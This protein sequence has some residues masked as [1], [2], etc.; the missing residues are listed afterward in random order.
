ML[1]LLV[2]H[3]SNE[4]GTNHEAEILSVFP[5]VS[6]YPLI[7]RSKSEGNCKIQQKSPVAFYGGEW[8][9][10]YTSSAAVPPESVLRLC[11]FMQLALRWHIKKGKLMVIAIN[12]L[13]APSC[14]PDAIY[15][16]CK[17][18]CNTRGCGCCKY[19]PECS[20]SCGGCK[21]LH[22]LKITLPEVGK[23]YRYSYYNYI[24]AIPFSHEVKM[25]V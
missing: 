7:R 1:Y 23:C 18:E 13:P 16:V 9:I 15:C 14:L 2:I 10:G 24:E 21:G 12:L 8:L 20:L 22:C 11:A 6:I 5:Q 17:I 19:E 3:T 25:S 4:F